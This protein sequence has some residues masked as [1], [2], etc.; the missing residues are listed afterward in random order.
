MWIIFNVK[1]DWIVNDI[2]HNFIEVVISSI[3]FLFNLFEISFN[4]LLI[5]RKHVLKIY[6]PSLCVRP[7]I[8]YFWHL[9]EFVLPQLSLLLKLWIVWWRRQACQTTQMLLDLIVISIPLT[10]QDI[11]SVIECNKLQFVPNIN[12]FLDVL[13]NN[14][15]PVCCWQN[16]FSLLYLLF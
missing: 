15:L 13:F 1:D 3:Q 16:F 11:L 7:S 8:K 6:V 4:N 2:C 14:K 5:G 10:D 12:Y 9:I